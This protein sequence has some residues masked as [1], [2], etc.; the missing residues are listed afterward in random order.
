MGKRKGGDYFLGRVSL[1]E[2][3]TAKLRLCNICRLLAGRERF[4]RMS[5]V[6]VARLLAKLSA[7]PLHLQFHFHLQSHTRALPH[8]ALMGALR[9]VADQLQVTFISLIS[10]R[11]A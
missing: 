5:G 11:L 8:L 4:S 1:S 9:K 10:Q 6:L 2:A 7:P 3:I